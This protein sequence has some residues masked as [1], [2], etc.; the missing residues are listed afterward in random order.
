MGNNVGNWQNYVYKRN[1]LGKPR[2]NGYK[3]QYDDCFI[4]IRDACI[5]IKLNPWADGD[6]SLHE[7]ERIVNQE[8]KKSA[9][10][11]RSIAFG[12]VGRRDREKRQMVSTR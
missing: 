10:E 9:R 12:S 5:R 7:R 6:E 4:L 11:R 2:Y 8:E 3:Q 1:E